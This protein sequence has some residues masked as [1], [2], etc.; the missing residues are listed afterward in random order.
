MAL[1]LS[2]IVRACA[3]GVAVW[4]AASVHATTSTSTTPWPEVPP[5]VKARVEWVAK[6]ARI[7]GLPSRI[8]RFESTASVEEMLGHYRAFWARSP[9]GKP[10]EN[11]AGGWRS[12]S[13]RHGPFQIA[14]QVKPRD[15]GGS[16]GLV[17]VMN[18]LEAKADYVP[19]NLPK[20]SGSRVLQVTESVDGPIRSFLVT[21]T[22]TQGV[23]LNAQLYR[24]ELRSQGWKP[25]DQMNAPGIRGTPSH[26]SGFKRGEESLDMTIIET[27]ARR[28]RI[29][30][31]LTLPASKEPS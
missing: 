25:L 21:L 1:S 13:T 5:P 16:E 9:N 7:N 24:D 12:I 11:E 23:E 14:V 22:S 31:N 27:K 20:V 15:A 17:S 6:D 26:F 30:V 8:E 10:M 18:V 29:T 19:R 2:G 4:A 28:S 3:C